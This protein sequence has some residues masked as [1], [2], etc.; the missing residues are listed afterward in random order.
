[1]AGIANALVAS[2][3]RRARLV[4]RPGDVPLDAAARPEDLPP[5]PRAGARLRRAGREPGPLQRLPG[6]RAP[7]GA[8]GLAPEFAAAIKIF[9]LSC[10]VVAGVFGAATVSRRILVLQAAPAAAR[11]LVLYSRS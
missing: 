8:A 5:L 9:F 7:L 1:M 4:P 3:R 11:S 10:V 6:R 2:R